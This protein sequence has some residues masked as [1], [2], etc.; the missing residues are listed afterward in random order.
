[1]LSGKWNALFHDRE[2]FMRT[3]ADVRFLRISAAVQRRVAKAT[4][5][6]VAVWLLATLALLGWQAWRSWHTADIAARAVAVEQAEAKVAAES[7]R[8]EDVARTLTERQRYFEAFFAN[9]F[10]NNAEARDEAAEA[11]RAAAAQTPAESDAAKGDHL[12]ELRAIGARQDRLALA[13]IGV[14]DARAARAEAALRAVGIRPPASDAARGGPFIPAADRLSAPTPRDAAFRRLDAAADR[15][16]MLEQL[17]LAI[18]SNLPADHMSLSSGFGY[19]RDPFTGGAAMHAGLD[20]TGEHGSPIRAAAAGRVSFVG[21]KS[22]YGN[23]V[24]VDHGHGIMTRYAHLSGF[25]ARLGDLVVPGQQIARMG[26]TGRS[27]GTHLHFEVHVGGTAV[28]PRR[29]LEAN[30][31]VLEVKA[32]AGEHIRSRRGAR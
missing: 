5:A 13:L 17:V 23:V 7:G 6:V 1:M 19:R 25:T 10:G 16:D 32:D 27:T 22:G 4:L 15:M 14:V 2:I 9:Q 31:D 11:A 3:G 29:F 12:S 8:I 21:V 30:P 24:E 20:F 18:P 28:N 26:S